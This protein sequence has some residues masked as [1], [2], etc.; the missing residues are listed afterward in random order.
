MTISSLPQP[1]LTVPYHSFLSAHPFSLFITSPFPLCSPPIFPFSP[2]VFSSTSTSTLFF[3]CWAFSSFLFFSSHL[4]TSIFSSPLLVF[5]PLPFNPPT[6][7]SCH[8]FICSKYF[9]QDAFYRWLCILSW[10]ERSVEM[11]G[12]DYPLLVPSAGLSLGWG[13]GWGGW[14][15]VSRGSGAPLTGKSKCPLKSL[16]FFFSFLPCHRLK[17]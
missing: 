1:S 3:F 10:Q 13:W 16:S 5:N 15:R 7:F 4:F 11:D 2:P 9:G 6:P 14:G 12:P 8:F 17:M